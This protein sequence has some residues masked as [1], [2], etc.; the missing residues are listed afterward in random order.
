[1]TVRTDS[2]DLPTTCDYDAD[3]DEHACESN[4]QSLL[5]ACEQASTLWAAAGSASRVPRLL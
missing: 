1:V 4:D 2:D 5:A 3:A